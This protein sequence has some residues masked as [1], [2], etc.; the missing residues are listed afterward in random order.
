MDV[1]KILIFLIQAIKMAS[2]M[3]IKKSPY[4]ERLSGDIKDRYDEKIQKCGGIDPYFLKPKELSTNSKDFPHITI[5]DIINYMIHSESSFTKKSFENY[6]GTEAYTFFESGF[7]VNIGSKRN[8]NLV[9][10]K[11][12]VS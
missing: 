4:Y 7:V 10:V 11:G 2:N 8:N 6:K 3:E 1:I 12:K 9:I 5:Y